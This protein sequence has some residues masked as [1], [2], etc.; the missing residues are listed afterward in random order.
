[1]NGSINA[2]ETSG[3][4]GGMQRGTGFFAQSGIYRRK[5]GV[6]L[7]G[8]RINTNVSYDNCAGSQLWKSVDGGKSF[9]CTTRP[10]A[11]YCSNVASAANGN[12]SCPEAAKCYDCK[13]A[14]CAKCWASLPAAECQ[15]CGKYTQFITKMCDTE[16]NPNF[17]APG[18]MCMRT[19]ILQ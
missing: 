14:E 1:M 11:G 13:Q 9:S 16:E 8:T 5:D 19:I 17:L 18:D 12:R 7:H 2:N 3:T 15:R 6:L 4:A 10:C